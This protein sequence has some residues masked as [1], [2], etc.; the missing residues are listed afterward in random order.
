MDEDLSYLDLGDD[1]NEV[2]D[3]KSVPGGEYEVRLVDLSIAATQKD[4][5]RQQLVVLLEV[6]GDPLAKTIYHYIR[7]PK[8]SDPPRDAMRMKRARKYFYQAFGIP[9]AG[10]VVFQDYIGNTAWVT[11]TEQSDPQYGTQNRISRFSRAGE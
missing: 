6:I 4:A 3:E 2:P 10:K 9:L 5:T 11:L 7:L 8:E 1:L